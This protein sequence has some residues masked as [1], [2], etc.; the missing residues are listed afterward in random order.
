MEKRQNEFR[1]IS[2]SVKNHVEKLLKSKKIKADQAI[3]LELTKIIGDLVLN[4][5]FGEFAK[6]SGI[7]DRIRNESPSDK[8]D[9]FKD[10]DHWIANLHFETIKSMILNDDEF[11]ENLKE[12]NGH[13]NK[14]Y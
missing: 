2:A 11:S 3:S 6:V 12:G 9:I 14:I 10:F 8:V 13:I 4:K 5:I 1:Q 7:F